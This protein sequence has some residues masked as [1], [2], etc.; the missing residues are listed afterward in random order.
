MK[1][2]IITIVLDGEPWIR[3]HLPEFEKLTAMGVDW[4]W[5]IREGVASATHCTKWCQ[6]MKPRFSEDGTHEYLGSLFH[7]ER[8]DIRGKIIWD[9]KVSMFN[10]AL[11]RVNEPCVLMQIDSDELWTAI[12]LVKICQLFA[13][14][15][16]AKRAYFKCD[17]YVGENIFTTSLNTYGNGP[18]EWLRAWRFK[19]GMIFDRHEPP[20]LSGTQGPAI[21]RETTW[22]NGLVFRHESYTTEKQVALKE[23]YYGYRDAVRHWKRLQANKVWPARLADFFPWVRDEARVNKG[24]NAS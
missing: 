3:K 10:D 13:D 1:L 12:Q 16:Q 2:H 17:Y 8:C 4:K 23:K 6:Q 11:L 24:I 9:G 18:E 7:H 22:Q 15:P 14:Y 20:M 19:P 5:H 21:P